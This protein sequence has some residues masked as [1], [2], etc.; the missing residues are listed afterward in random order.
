MNQVHVRFRD[1]RMQIFVADKYKIE[2]DLLVLFIQDAV[3]AVIR[4][5]E[6]LFFQVVAVQDEDED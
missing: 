1:D 5:D 6:V 2:G 4:W 3:A